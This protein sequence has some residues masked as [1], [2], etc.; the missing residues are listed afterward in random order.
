MWEYFP[1]ERA[2]AKQFLKDAEK[3]KWEG[4]QG[5]WQQES[6]AKEYLDQVKSSADTDCTPIMMRFGYTVH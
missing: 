1:L 3:E 5:E 4:I 2:T 6:P